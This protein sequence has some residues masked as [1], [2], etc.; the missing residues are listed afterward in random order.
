MRK[1]V[2]IHGRL[3]QRQ[4]CQQQQGGG[5]KGGSAPAPAPPAPPPPPPDITDASAVAQNKADDVRRRSGAGATMLTGTSGAADPT[6]T[7]ATLGGG[8][9]T[10]LGA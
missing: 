2:W 5:G 8:T 3:M 10:L 9:K 6:V 7:T 4:P 1:L